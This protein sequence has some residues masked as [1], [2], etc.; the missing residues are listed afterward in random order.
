M[1]NW[2]HSVAGKTPNNPF[3]S[4]MILIEV[5]TKTNEIPRF[6]YCRKDKI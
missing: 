3:H 5:R 6:C 4:V 1:N 2:L